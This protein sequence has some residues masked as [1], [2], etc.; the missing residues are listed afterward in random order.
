VIAV[1]EATLAA[2]ELRSLPRA[3]FAP[4]W[5]ALIEA[6]AR[7]ASRPIRPPVGTR[8]RAPLCRASSIRRGCASSAPT[9]TGMNTLPAPTAG[10]AI[11]AKAA[12]GAHSTMMS[13]AVPKALFA[14]IRLVINALRAAPKPP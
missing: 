2:P 3:L 8:I 1:D 5:A 14:E 10:S 12:A 9:L 4:Y 7:T 13:A 6:A 11:S